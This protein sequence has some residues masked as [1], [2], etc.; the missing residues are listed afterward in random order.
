MAIAAGGEIN[1]S[2]V[3]IVAQDSKK[4]LSDAVSFTDLNVD[5]ACL[6][7]V[8]KLATDEPM[9]IVWGEGEVGLYNL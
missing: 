3:I 9:V 4:K 5:N 6:T 8:V 1:A 2:P 7:G